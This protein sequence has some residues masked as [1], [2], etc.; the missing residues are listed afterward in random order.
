MYYHPRNIKHC[1]IVK[2]NKKDEYNNRRQVWSGRKINV[3]LYKFEITTMM[4]I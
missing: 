3:R 1:L 2:L 4:F